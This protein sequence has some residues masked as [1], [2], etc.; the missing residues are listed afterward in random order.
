MVIGLFLYFQNV[1]DADENVNVVNPAVRDFDV[2]VAEN[3][4]K[5]QGTQASKS[6]YPIIVTGF[7]GNPV[8]RPVISRRLSAT[9]PDAD[10]TNPADCMMPSLVTQVNKELPSSEAP[11]IAEPGIGGIP[12]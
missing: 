12:H 7:V 9:G 3:E 1:T 8:V 4:S 6:G 10:P 2:I 11:G 5:L